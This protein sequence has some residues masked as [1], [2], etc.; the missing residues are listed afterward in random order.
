MYFV[1]SVIVLTQT[2]VYYT[3][4]FKFFLFSIAPVGHTAAHSPQ[5]IQTAVS[6][7]AKV[8]A[9]LIASVGHT[10]EHFLH[11]IHP[12]SQFFL[13]IPPCP[14]LNNLQN[15]DLFLEPFQLYF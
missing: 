10:F 7:F 13:T 12:T 14:Y 3:H 5:L 9:K 1:R 8:P 6:I 2:T 15:I 4:F 11:P